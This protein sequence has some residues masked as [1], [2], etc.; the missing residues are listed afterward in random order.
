MKQ[1]LLEI[2]NGQFAREWILENRAG[3]RPSKQLAATIAVC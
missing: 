2:Q 3:A 1:I